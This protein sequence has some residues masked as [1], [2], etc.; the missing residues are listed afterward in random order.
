MDPAGRLNGAAKPV[1]APKTAELIADQL[2]ASIVRGV[3]KQGDALPTEVELVKQFGVS[4][5]TLRE[6]FRILESESLISVRRGSRGGVL[7]CAPETTVAARNF[8]LLLQMSGTTLTDLYE[9][10]KVFEPAAAQM[11]ARRATDED[12]AE[13]K[14][15]ADALAALVNEGAAGADLGEWTAAVFR[16]HDL[17][18]ERAGNNTLR[19]FNAVLREVVTRHMARV[20]RTATD[21]EKIEKQF[22]QTLRAFRKFIT[23]VEAHDDVAAR[24]HW[25]AH[26]ERAGR[27]M[28]W[29]DLAKETVIDLY[30]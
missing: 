7:V 9:A 2:R 29:G 13:L 28:L 21:N 22:K 24:D 12:I 23:L 17:I 4:R 14:A 5:P 26:M 20:M 15:A 3:L 6:A 27:R 8:G 25:A 30:V 18:M 11:L 16:F 1:R 10:R 19:L